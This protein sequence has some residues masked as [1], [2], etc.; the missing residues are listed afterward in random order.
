M[1]LAA[2]SPDEVARIVRGR[3]L[4]QGTVVPRGCGHST[5]GQAAGEAVLDMRGLRAIR[6]VRADRAVVEAGAT[7][8]EVLAAAL[9]HGATPPVLPDYL[10]LSVGG[11]LSAGGV[12]GTSHRYGLQIDNVLEL[13]VV[14]PAGDLV[15]C[16]PAVHPAL[17]D[18][19][20]GGLGRHGVITAAVLRLVA[21]PARVRSYK[22]PCADL[23]DLLAAQ[24]RVGADH[25]AGQAKYDVGWR[26][27]LSVV[28]YEPAAPVPGAEGAQELGYAEF[29]DRMSPDVAEL[30]ALGEW[31]R[32]HP[33][34]AV[35]LPADRAAEVIER[36]LAETGPADLGVS[37]VV[38]ITPLTRDRVMFA[39]LRTASPGA[40]LPIQMLVANDVL[41]ARA[42]AAGGSR[43]P[44]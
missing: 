32:P 30:V 33:W 8:R 38:L 35:L 34:A 5:A 1:V 11:T 20:R 21:A 24:R 28:S 9:A 26:Y 12:G 3:R 27:E 19:V 29:A 13:E 22:M 44:I 23:R 14:T 18:A 41:Y 16:S 6:E 17:F 31:A 36:T 40:A 7:W 25:I 2:G 43:Y 15:R 4:V 10:D 39:L 37:G 42:R